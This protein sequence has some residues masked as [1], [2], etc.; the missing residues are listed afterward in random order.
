M[1]ANIVKLI[2]I[3]CCICV[4]STYSWRCF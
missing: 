4:P 2:G 1:S 3:E